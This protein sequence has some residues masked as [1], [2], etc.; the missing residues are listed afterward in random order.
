MPRAC[1]AAARL[2]SILNSTATF[3]FR[4]TSLSLAT[5]SASAYVRQQGSRGG[6]AE[7]ATRHLRRCG[8]VV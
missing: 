8:R 2:A 1:S 3:S 4:I 5:R 6:L 7:L